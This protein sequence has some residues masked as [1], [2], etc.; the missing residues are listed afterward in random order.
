ML[1][2]TTDCNYINSGLS[3]QY[4]RW[5]Y[6]CN[7]T[8]NQRSINRIPVTTRWQM[9]YIFTNGWWNHANHRRGEKDSSLGEISFFY[10]QRSK[11]LYKSGKS[12]I[13]RIV[14]FSIHDLGGNRDV[15]MAGNST[16]STVH[17]QSL[18]EPKFKIFKIDPIW[19]Y[20]HAWQIQKR[21]NST[22]WSLGRL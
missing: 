14:P 16:C 1:V 19:H 18:S 13:W 7:V 3:T 17:F 5:Y 8:I 20:L 9:P 21:I 11:T 22:S 6:Y 10:Q 15:F 4:L 12:A 2:T